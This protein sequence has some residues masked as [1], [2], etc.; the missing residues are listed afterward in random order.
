MRL[1]TPSWTSIEHLQPSECFNSQYLQFDVLLRFFYAL[2]LTTNFRKKSGQP[3]SFNLET[4]NNDSLHGKSMYTFNSSPYS[5]SNSL[6]NHIQ[7]INTYFQP[8]FA[9]SLLCE[10]KSKSNSVSQY[11]IIIFEV[12]TGVAPNFIIFPGCSDIISFVWAHKTCMSSC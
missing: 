5:V 1:L 12:I 6:F 3:K 10:D 8:L 2:F 7:I 11:G 9:F 4:I